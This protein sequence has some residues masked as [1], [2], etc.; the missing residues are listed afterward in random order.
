MKRF[1]YQ[2][3]LW[4]G[5]VSG[6][7]VF[8]ISITGALYAFQEEISGLGKYHKVEVLDVP[9]LPPSQLQSVAERVLPGK[10]LH[11]V[12]YNGKGKSAEAIFY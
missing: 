4:L 8:L 6:L 9:K 2:I 7:L 10:T 11:S 3:H 5:L 12:K 1:F